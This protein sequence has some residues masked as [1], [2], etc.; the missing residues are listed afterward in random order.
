MNNSTRATDASFCVNCP[1]GSYSDSEGSTTCTPCA[2]GTAS[3]NVG[4][5]ACQRCEVGTYQEDEGAT[6]CHSCPAGRT[7]Q[8]RSAVSLD[9]C[10]CPTN[11]YQPR[12]S[13]SCLSCPTGMSCDSENSTVDAI[14][15]VEI[16][17][18]ANSRLLTPPSYPYPVAEEGFMVLASSPTTPYKC[19]DI[20]WCPGGPPGSCARNR[21]YESVGCSKCQPDTYTVEDGTCEPCEG[22]AAPALV[23]SVGVGILV[24]LGVFVNVVNR[25]QL[26]QSNSILSVVITLGLTVTAV[27]TLSIFSNLDV[28]WPE[29]LLSMMKVLSLVSF[30]LK[31]LKI[32]CVVGQQ[33]VSNMI[34]RQMMAPGAALYIALI[35]CL[36]K[37]FIEPRVHLPSQLINSIG[38]IFQIFFVAVFLSSLGPVVCYKHPNEL[39]YSMTSDPSILCNQ[40]GEH[41]SLVVVSVVTIVIVVLPFLAMITYATVRYQSLVGSSI[42]SHHHLMTFRFLFFRYKPDSYYYGCLTSL[43]GVLV[44]LVPVVFRDFPSLQLLLMAAILLAFGSFQQHKQPWRSYLPNVIDSTTNTLLILLIVCVSMTTDFEDAEQLLGIVAAVIFIGL[45]LA[46]LAVICFHLVKYFQPSPFFSSF[47]C[48]H[49]AEAAAQ[50]RYLQTLIVSRSRGATCFLDSDNLTNLQ[51]LFDIVRCRCGRL[52][53][54][55]TADTLRRPWCAGEITMAFQTHK[56]VS[57][58]YHS[59]FAS[60]TMQEIEADNISTFLAAADFKL[61]EYGI[62]NELIAQAFRWFLGELPDRYTMRSDLVGRDRLQAVVDWLL[63][64]SGH[65]SASRSDTLDLKPRSLVVSSTPNDDEATAVAGILVSKIQQRVLDLVPAGIIVLADMPAHNAEVLAAVAA[66]HA[67]LVILTPKSFASSEQLQIIVG[68]T[69]DQVCCIPVNTPSFRFPGQDF[70]EKDIPRRFGQQAELVE[71]SIRSFLKCI[72]VPFTTYAS[73]Q[74]LDVQAESVVLRIPRVLGLAST[75][76]TGPG[77]KLSGT[78]IKLMEDHLGDS[79]EEHTLHN[80]VSKTELDEY[81]SKHHPHGSVADFALHWACAEQAQV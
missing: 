59:S 62:T 26:N 79:P 38:A 54:Y 18:A 17:A 47:I 68:C 35:V 70:F 22:G 44:C 45:F 49:K 16:T 69:S 57:A 56:N 19:K 33:S 48:H 55:L 60:P 28:E 27:Q 37:R 58:I 8:Y 71:T 5:T 14:P 78:S 7:T 72:A 42:A 34:L 11:T 12:A 20:L 9:D 81:I 61:V 31:V 67:V 46:I 10:V 64:K 80:I 15:A 24:V 77:G 4:Q 63:K 36:K 52:I 1:I 23:A 32:E 41:L 2:T 65:R 50:A 43:R 74:V 75:T 13:E 73:Q 30:D 40:E 21:D 6:E 29:P 39:G 76:S 25:N 3:N 51:D 53:V 66:A